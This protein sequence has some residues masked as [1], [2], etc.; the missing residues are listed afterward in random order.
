MEAG[1]EVGR[2]DRAECDADDAQPLNRVPRAE[3]PTDLLQPRSAPDTIPESP[4]SPQEDAHKTLLDRDVPRRREK[5][6]P[7][8][9]TAFS[10][11]YGY[12]QCAL[13]WVVSVMGGWLPQA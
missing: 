13:V 2:G 7:S 8:V 11:L 12:L 6:D 1:R 10:I 3:R 4:R 9:S 5:K